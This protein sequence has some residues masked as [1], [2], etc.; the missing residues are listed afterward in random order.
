MKKYISYLILMLFGLSIKGC[1]DLEEVPYNQI[2]SSNFYQVKEDVIK[3]FL[4]TYEHGYW[5]TSSSL[6]DLQELSADQLMTPTRESHWYD[7]GKYVRIHNHEWKADEDYFEPAWNGVWKGI[8]LANNSMEDLKELDPAKFDLT[9][10][11]MNSFIAELR[12]MRAWYYIKAVDL[13]KNIPL[14]DKLPGADDA[15]VQADPKTIF[16]FIETELLESLDDLGTEGVEL[17]S[18]NRWS[19]AGA[20]ALLARLYLN[21]EVYIGEAHYDEC[22]KI[23]QDIIDGVYGRYDIADRWD[24][25]FDYDNENCEENIFSFPS[26]YGYT[27]WHYNLYNTSLPFMAHLYFDFT[28]WGQFGSPKFALQPGRDVDSLEYNFELGKPFLKFQ[29][30]P[31]DV[32]LKKY[33][34]LGGNRREGMFLYAYL[35]YNNDQDTLSSDVGDILF[36][37]DQ[38][39]WFG[40]LKPGEENPDK[41]SNMLHADQ[42][43]GV[44]HVKYP[45]YPDSDDQKFEA[46]YAEIRL[47]EIYYSL[48]ECKFRKGDMASAKSLLNYVRRRYYPEGSE[49]LYSGNELTE[50][51]LLDEWGREFLAEGRRRTDLVR[52]NKFTTGE[53][54]GKDPDAGGDYLNIFPIYQQEMD[55][56]PQLIQ[57]PGY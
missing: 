56:S 35:T 53:W 32:R 55:L 22:E 4:R 14:I 31:D 33:K 21:A 37:R 45:I 8:I 16:N 46:D 41:E 18:R 11:E 49:S 25:P 19:E 44:Y 34:N 20:M 51:E 1:T 42:N 57:N 2:G 26:S 47:A 24:A 38:V 29:K 3:S 12:V 15:S 39:G 23:C 27:H 9:D 7:G 17:D 48:A 5:F 36:I 50:Q 6:Y 40:T 43:S 13:F 10:D 28:E 52:F 30:Y 54:W